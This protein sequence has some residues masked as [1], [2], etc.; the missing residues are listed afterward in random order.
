MTKLISSSC[1]FQLKKTK[2]IFM[3]PQFVLFKAAFLD[4][5]ATDIALDTKTVVA[6]TFDIGAVIFLNVS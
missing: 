5:L 4:F 2:L 1:N 6:V 3:D